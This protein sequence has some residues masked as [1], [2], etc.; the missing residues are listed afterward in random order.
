MKKNPAMSKHI[1][2]E[3]VLSLTG[4]NA[5]DKYLHRPSEQGAVVAALLNTIN[6]QNASGISD[7]KL[8]EGIEKTAKALNENKGAA[9]VVCGSND[10]NVQI[11]VNAINEA[12]QAPGNT[13]SWSQTLNYR[14]GID[15]DFA[16]LVNDMN[17]GA[18]N[19]LLVV[20]A[21]PAYTWYDNKKIY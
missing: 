1:H 14:Q 11:L 6:G 3:S 15:G 4:A 8:K 21:N 18:V 17:A 9:L 19:A 20:E 2:F 13:I 16:T 5:D 10:V 12:I 7:A